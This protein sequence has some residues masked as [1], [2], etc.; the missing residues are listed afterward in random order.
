MAQT[1]RLRGAVLLA[2]CLCTIWSF[3]AQQAF[4]KTE[5]APEAL[6]YRSV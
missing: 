6:L 4:T 1:R 5:E 2:L 3:S